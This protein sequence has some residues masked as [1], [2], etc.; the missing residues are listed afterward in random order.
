MEVDLHNKKEG[1]ERTRGVGWNQTPNGSNAEWIKERANLEGIK[2]LE[3]YC[4]YPSQARRPELGA[5][6]LM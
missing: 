3:S 1:E 4:K 5:G 2:Q 6:A